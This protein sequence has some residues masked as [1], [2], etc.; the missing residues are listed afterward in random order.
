M[1]T[2][3]DETILQDLEKAEAEN[4][5]Q[6]KVID[7]TRTI[8]RSRK[9]C[10]PTGALWGQPVLCDFGGARIRGS[11][12]RWRPEDRKSATELL[13]HLWMANVI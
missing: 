1:L 4:P 13:Q 12:L 2:V 6:S 8:Y 3:A 5:L 11:M 7:D 9:L 10:L